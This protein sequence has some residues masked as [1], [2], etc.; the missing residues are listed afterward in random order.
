M[1]P[2]LPNNSP[3]TDAPQIL[4]VE[5]DPGARMLYRIVLQDDYALTFASDVETALKHARQIPFDLVL[6]DISLGGTRNGIDLLKRLRAEP[7]YANAPLV[8]ITA[9]A[10]PGDRR[11]LLAAGFDAYVAKP[12]TH[13]KLSETVEQHLP[14]VQTSR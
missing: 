14:D 2:L 6:I 3:D 4:A 9:H 10:L 1:H 11:R 5:D 8:A 13:L 12:F 7:R